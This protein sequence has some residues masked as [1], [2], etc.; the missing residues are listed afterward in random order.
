MNFLFPFAERA[1]FFRVA[2]ILH[3]G[4]S[5]KKNRTTTDLHQGIAAGDKKIASRGIIFAG[6]RAVVQLRSCATV[7]TDHERNIFQR[8]S[9][10]LGFHKAVLNSDQRA[11]VQRTWRCFVRFLLPL[12]PF[13]FPSFHSPNTMGTKN[14]RPSRKERKRSYSDRSF[15]IAAPA[16]FIVARCYSFVSPRIPGNCYICVVINRSCRQL[17]ATTVSP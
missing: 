9:L 16:A 1:E 4:K 5:R 15:F 3:F 14:G 10:I 6:D 11:N 7:A 13:F 12:F 8:A 2:K 17:R